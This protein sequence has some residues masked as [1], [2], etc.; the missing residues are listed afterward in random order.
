MGENNLSGTLPSCISQ[1]TNLNYLALFNNHFTGSIPYCL[2]SLSELEILFL[3]QNY[4]SGILPTSIGNLTKLQI[5][6]ISSNEITGTVPATYAG[7]TNIHLLYLSD[8]KLHKLED[9]LEPLYDRINKPYW[10][11]LGGNPW[12]CP[13]PKD[14]PASCDAECSKCNTGNKHTSCVQCVADGNCGW[15]NDGPNCLEGTAGG[16]F[17]MYQCKPEDWSYGS[18]AC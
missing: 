3:S 4:F 16:P 14:V 9:G 17:Y 11:L 5:L 6:D 12:F 18:N 1:L 7:L 8:N 13:L 15:C 10:C 2:G